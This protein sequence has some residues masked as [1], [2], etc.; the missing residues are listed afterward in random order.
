MN[1]GANVVLACRDLQKAEQ[2]A[3]EITSETQNP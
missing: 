3:H 1:A 2:A